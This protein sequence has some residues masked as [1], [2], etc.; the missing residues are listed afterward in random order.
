VVRGFSGG[1][2]SFVEV[3][4]ARRPWAFG[5]PRERDWF[6]ARVEDRRGGVVFANLFW[7]TAFDAVSSVTLPLFTSSGSFRGDDW[8]PASTC[9]FAT[10]IIAWSGAAFA[11]LVIFKIAPDYGF[12]VTFFTPA[13]VVVSLAGAV[14]TISHCSVIGPNSE[15]KIS[16]HAEPSAGAGW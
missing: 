16:R 5:V 6:P 10:C 2:R 8:Q 13:V 3:P 4:Q 7:G 14:R 1:P 12:L 15:W 9:D 11:I